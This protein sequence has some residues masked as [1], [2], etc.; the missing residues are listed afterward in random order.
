MI[1]FFDIDGTT[2]DNIGKFYSAW[3]EYATAR[4]IAWTKYDFTQYG[5]KN[6]FGPTTE[7]DIEEFESS[8][9]FADFYIEDT[10]EGVVDVMKALLEKG[11]TIRF[12]TSRNSGYRV[13]LTP[14][15][16]ALFGSELAANRKTISLDRLT[17]KW[18]ESLG[19]GEIGVVFAQD[20]VAAIKAFQGRCICVDDTPEKINKF[21][22]A[23]FDCLVK[24][25][26]YNKDC[27]S[28]GRRFSDWKEL[29]NLREVIINA[30]ED[31]NDWEEL[32]LREACSNLTEENRALREQNDSLTEDLTALKEVVKTL[33]QEKE[34]MA[35]LL[36]EYRVKEIN[37]R[38]KEVVNG[39]KGNTELAKDNNLI[40]VLKRDIEC[41]ASK[42]KVLQEEN[43]VLQST[44]ADFVYKGKRAVMPMRLTVGLGLASINLMSVSKVYSNQR[45]TRREALFGCINKLTYVLGKLGV[46]YALSG[47]TALLMYGCDEDVYTIT[48]YVSK[49]DIKYVGNILSTEFGIPYSSRLDTPEA[50]EIVEFALDGIRVKITCGARSLIGDN[51]IDNVFTDKT[52]INTINGVYVQRPEQLEEDARILGD[53]ELLR[54]AKALKTL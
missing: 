30:M 28:N 36:Q 49:K 17:L 22:E 37:Q 14:K 24:D 8:A 5:I 1:W 18:V 25:A 46:R 29:L 35:K 34:Q 7:V 39:S 45:L 48:V 47:K 9:E 10:F 11:D 16:R 42:I 19:L 54:K 38:E 3:Y 51:V 32:D 23:G 41:K 15:I 20:K 43:D 31:R 2:I 40:D 21:I 6:I 52:P 26:K 13:E 27:G 44:L 33:T 53:D 12:L 50:L 4:N